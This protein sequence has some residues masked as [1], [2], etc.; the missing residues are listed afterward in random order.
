MI[1]KSG[2]IAAA[3]AV[4]FLSAGSLPVLAQEADA[5][6]CGTDRTI[7]IAE[8]TWP[9][10]AALAHIHATILSEGYGCDVAIVAGD[11]VPT[12]SSMLN[13]GTPAVAPELWTSTIEDAWAKGIEDGTVVQLSDAITDGTVEGWFIPE[14]TQAEHPDLTT[15]E[16]VIARPDLFPD[17]E[18][19]NKGRLY[20]CPPGWACELS[21]TA[22]FDAYDMDETWNIFSPGSGGAL[23]ASI[24]RAFT[25]EEPILF[26]YWGPTAILGKYP[27]VQ[28]DLGETKPEVYACN[29]DPDCTEAAG[30]TAYPS[31]PAVVGAASWIQDEAPVVAEYFSKVGLTNA[32]ISELLVY[33]DENQADAAATAENFLRT[34]Q[35]VWSGWVPAEVADKVMAALG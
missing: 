15:A 11:T 23:D 4:A 17:P 13:R 34:K 5:A 1:L 33:G 19:S 26:Y 3:I 31:S 9:S 8:M 35:D 22:L 25:R 10:A 30:V 18:D 20:S 29:T 27:A 14:Y 21:T 28:L 12:A 16:A 32:E 24:A 6:Q 7:D 2:G